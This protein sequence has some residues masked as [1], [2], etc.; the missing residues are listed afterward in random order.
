MFL[1]GVPIMIRH[2]EFESFAIYSSEIFDLIHISIPHDRLSLCVYGYG[3]G[4]IGKLSLIRQILVV[5]KILEGI[6]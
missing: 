4:S 6:L 1:K 3:I 5:F 2:I